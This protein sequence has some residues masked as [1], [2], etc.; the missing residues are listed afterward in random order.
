MGRRQANQRAAIASCATMAWETRWLDQ[1]QVVVAVGPRIA[2][3]AGAEQ[4]DFLRVA[5]GQQPTDDLLERWVQP[6]ALGL[7]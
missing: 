1:Q 6:F 2:T 7:A 5:N 4:D 3:G